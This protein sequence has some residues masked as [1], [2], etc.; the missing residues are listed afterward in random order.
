MFV[1][2]SVYLT[3][4]ETISFN[5]LVGKEDG[6]PLP[7]TSHENVKEFETALA[8]NGCFRIYTKDTYNKVAEALSHY[9]QYI[10]TSVPFFKWMFGLSVLAFVTSIEHG[11]S[12]NSHSISYTVK[13]PQ[14]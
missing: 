13:L 12:F 9:S 2:N 6:R 14:L 10:I 11:D 4:Q 3:H 8:Y 1:S 7:P 5:V